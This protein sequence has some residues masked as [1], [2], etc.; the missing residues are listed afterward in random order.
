MIKTL[1]LGI[2][3]HYQKCVN[4]MQKQMHARFAEALLHLSDHI[5]E[6]DTFIF[7]LTRAEFGEYIGTT[8]ETVTKIFHELAADQ[9]I[10]MDGKRI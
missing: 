8:R 4:K 5:F 2:V 6:C 3:Y 9:L 10:K 1:S 7:P